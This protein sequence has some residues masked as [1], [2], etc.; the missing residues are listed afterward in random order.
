[1]YTE[2]EMLNALTVLRSEL[3]SKPL[4]KGVDPDS[5][6]KHSYYEIKSIL[7]ELTEYVEYL[8]WLDYCDA[9]EQEYL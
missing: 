6:I 8:E 4:L 2:K 3:P 1:M 9:S 5:M 7:P